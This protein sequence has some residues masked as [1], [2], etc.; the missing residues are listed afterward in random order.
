M[1]KCVVNRV[2]KVTSAQKG[3][4]QVQIADFPGETNN[5]FF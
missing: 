1:L 5:F 2:N 4:L 3:C